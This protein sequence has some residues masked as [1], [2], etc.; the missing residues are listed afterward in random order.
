MEQLQSRPT[1]LRA[2]SPLPWL[3]PLL[4]LILAGIFLALLWNLLPFNRGRAD[5]TFAR[6]MSAHHA[7]AVDMALILR[8]RVEDEQLRLFLL[9]MALTQQTQIGQMQGWLA[10][11]NVPLAGPEPIMGGQGEA[12]G[13]AAQEQV[14]SLRHLPVAEAEV[15]FLQLMIRHHQGG[16]LMAE[17][18]LERNPRPQVARLAESIIAGQQSEIEYMT[19]LLQE[20][21]AEPLPPLAPME[22]GSH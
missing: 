20:R 6:D 2:S 21:G 8:D 16:V 14:N 3:R 18:I 4:L 12:M 7:Q 19:S 1:T 5:V 11:W 10:A 13:M 15:L 17:D 9:D 22:H